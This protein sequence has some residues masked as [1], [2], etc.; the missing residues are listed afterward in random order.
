MNFVICE[1]SLAHDNISRRSVWM[2]LCGP[3]AVAPRPCGVT[4]LFTA[5][6]E[7]PRGRTELLCRPELHWHTQQAPPA[8]RKGNWG[9][10]RFTKEVR[11]HVQGQQLGDSRFSGHLQPH[12]R[13]TTQRKFHLQVLFLLV[14]KSPRWQ[15]VL[16]LPEPPCQ[17]PLQ[18][19]RQHFQAFLSRT[20]SGNVTPW[21]NL[22]T[23]KPPRLVAPKDTPHLTTCCVPMPKCH[24]MKTQQMPRLHWTCPRGGMLLVSAVYIYTSVFREQQCSLVLRSLYAWG[25]VSS[26]TNLLQGDT[27]RSDF[28]R[29]IMKS[30]TFWQGA[31][32]SVW[33]ADRLLYH[34]LIHPV[35]VWEDVFDEL[36]TQISK[37]FLA[38]AWSSHTSGI[39]IH[40]EW[41]DHSL[42]LPCWSKW[43]H[44]L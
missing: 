12:H 23:I 33:Q 24:W 17:P 31:E 30:R 11:D 21:S 36:A 29:E 22:D 16:T 41:E 18:Q 26:Y 32:M 10:D 38:C 15:H 43:L 42:N 4:S 39:K 20:G 7:E 28:L 34:N 35:R 40:L 9:R 1:K 3:A 6:T 27:Q 37:E 8:L 44:L 2:L 19:D 5:D 25:E 13:I 14:S